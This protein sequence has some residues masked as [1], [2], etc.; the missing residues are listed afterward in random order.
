MILNLVK[1]PSS[2]RLI[3]HVGFV[4]TGSSA[5]QSWLANNAAGLARQGIFYEKGNPESIKYN[6]GSGNGERLRLY[7]NHFLRPPKTGRRLHRLIHQYAREKRLY[8]RYFKN[9][10]KTV[11]I[12]SEAIVLNDV[13]VA[14]LKAFV[15]KY[16]IELKIIAYVRD[17]IDFLFSLYAHEMRLEGNLKAQSIETYIR[18]RGEHPHIALSYLLVN[19]FAD[20]ELISYNKHKRDIARAFCN[21]TRIDYEKL[22]KMLPIRVNRSLDIDEMAVIRVIGQWWDQHLDQMAETGNPYT[23]PE[24]APGLASRYLV[25]TYKHKRTEIAATEAT[26][27]TLEE[28]YRKS[29]EA[30]NEDIGQKFSCALSYRYDGKHKPVVTKD[31]DHVDISILRDIARYLITQK[32]SLGEDWLACFA[33]C[34]SQLDSTASEIFRRGINM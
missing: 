28:K 14:A 11:I 26:L 12:S 16:H 2:R 18:D 20:V 31:I 21:A 3:L 19:N 22:D 4:K 9:R 15:E 27:Q 33:A 29:V 5:L 24:S 23:G 7:L 13:T 6:I 17:P 10:Y 34:A 25:N 1:G 30:F 32:R 8:H